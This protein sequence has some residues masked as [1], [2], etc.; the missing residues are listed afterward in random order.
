MDTLADM[1][2][3]KESEL[4]KVE[5]S[6]PETEEERSKRLRKE[7]RRKL[8]VSWKPDTA[9]VETRLFTHDPD[10]EVGHGDS[11]IRDAGDLK[12]EGRMLKLHKDLEEFDEDDDVGEELELF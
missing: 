9:L 1:S 2:K 3:P 4:K 7:G 10:E 12:G 5:D 8:R 11:M 6:P